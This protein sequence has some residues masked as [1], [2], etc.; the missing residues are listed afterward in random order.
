MLIIRTILFMVVLGFIVFSLFKSKNPNNNNNNNNNTIKNVIMN[1]LT[2]ILFFVVYYFVIAIISMIPL[3]MISSNSNS[4]SDS[5]LWAY[6]IILGMGLAPILSLITTIKLNQKKKNTETIEQINDN[7]I[8]QKDKKNPII[9]I[10]I[11]IVSFIGIGIILSTIFNFNTK[12]LSTNVFYNITYYNELIPGSKYEISIQDNGV[13]ITKTSFCSAVD[14]SPKTEKEMF[15]YSKENLEKLKTFI[16]NNF[17]NNYIEL[18]DNELTDRQKEVIQGILLG[19]YFFETNVEEYKY[20]IEY[21]K[22]DSLTYDIYFKNDNSILVK[23]LK[24]NSDYDIVSVNTYSLNFSQKNKNILFDYVEKEVKK[25]ND[26][27]IYK[28]STLQ[29]DEINIFN[30]IT[31]NNEAYL[32]NIESEAKLTYTISYNGINCPTPTLYLYSD[33]TYEYYYTFGTDNEKLIPKTG[34]FNYDITKII[35]NIDKYEEN[36]IGPYSIKEEN[37]K[38][39]T[40]YNTNTELQELLTSLDITLEKCLEQQ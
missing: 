23:K 1:I 17:S 27:I 15:N 5:G 25:E 2:F 13:E 18:N 40:T 28:Y 8:I 3:A 30:S 12:P 4:G 21:S 38:N 14:C 29:K 32:N 26:N 11:V 24:I 31:E 35:N 19:E 34:T 37:G 33:N 6:S 10:A 7:N 9:I 20:K 22:N 16:N 39:Y 36:S